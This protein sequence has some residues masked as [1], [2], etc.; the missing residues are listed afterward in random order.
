[1]IVAA[2]GEHAWAAHLWGVAESLRERCGVPLSPFERVDYEPAVAS[3]R[4]HLGEQ[5]FA[6]AWAEGRTMT[7]EQVLDRGFKLGQNVII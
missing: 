6:T 3:A 7:L 5:A 2:Q 4:T 1:M